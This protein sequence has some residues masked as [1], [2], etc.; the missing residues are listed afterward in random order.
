MCNLGLLHVAIKKFNVKKGYCI[1]TIDESCESYGEQQDHK[2][3]YILKT[4]KN[5]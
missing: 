1:Q 2:A 5:H 3:R 4:M